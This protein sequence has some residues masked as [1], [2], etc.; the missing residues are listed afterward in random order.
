MARLEFYFNEDERKELI[1]FILSS[2]TK[3]IPDILYNTPHYYV[4]TKL[5]E[6]EYYSQNGASRFF[7]VNSNYTSKPLNFIE[8]NVEE[9]VRFK[10]KQRCG[11]PYIDLVFYFGHAA[12]AIVKYKMS[13]IDYYSKFLNNDGIEF[14]S[15]SQLKNYYLEIS[16]FI[17]SKSKNILVQNQKKIISKKVLDELGVNSSSF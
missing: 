6:F 4:I 11:G 12:D 5:S 15:P 3:I 10:I 13:I 7:L 14:A 9:E 16:R 17:K 8:I 1:N 2:D